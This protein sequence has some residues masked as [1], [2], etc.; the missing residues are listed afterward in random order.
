MK[1]IVLLINPA[2][3]TISSYYHRR[4]VDYQYY[5]SQLTQ[6]TP[7]CLNK[8]IE[9]IPSLINQRFDWLF[10][11]SLSSLQEKYQQFTDYILLPDLLS[12]LYIYYLK[13]WI[14]IFPREQF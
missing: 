11:D 6:V 10:D 8:T 12:S 9:K 2:D 5:K 7:N 13:E 1:F 14:N 3:R 4:R